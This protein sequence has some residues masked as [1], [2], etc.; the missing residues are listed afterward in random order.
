[1]VKAVVNGVVLAESSNTVIVEGN[2]YF[3][4]EDVRKDEYFSESN[5]S[6]VC[7]WKGTASYYNANVDGKEINDIAWYYPNTKEKAMN[8]KNYVAF[9]K[10]KVDIA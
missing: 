4:P 2:H 6:T 1:M 7:P 3:P 9:Y 5:T 10:N 8:I